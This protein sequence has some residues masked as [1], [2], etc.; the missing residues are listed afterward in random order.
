[1][2]LMPTKGAKLTVALAAA[3]QSLNSFVRSAEPPDG[4]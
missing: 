3:V 4:T 1:M 2:V